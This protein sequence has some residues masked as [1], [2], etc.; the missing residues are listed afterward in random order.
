[1]G[2]KPSQAKPNKNHK[3][4]K[5]LIPAPT[6]D[7]RISPRGLQTAP[8]PQ[9]IPMQVMWRSHYPDVCSN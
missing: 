3:K 8:C 4:A 5:T 1:M 9:V 2:A 6:P 7:S